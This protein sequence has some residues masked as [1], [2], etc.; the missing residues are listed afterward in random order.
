MIDTNEYR[1][2]GKKKPN[3]YTKGVIVTFYD[4]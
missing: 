3:K 4:M 2:F 1:V